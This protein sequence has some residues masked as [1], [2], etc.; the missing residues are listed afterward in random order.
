ML[1]SARKTQY[2]N[3]RKNSLT[4]SRPGSGPIIFRL[5]PARPDEDFFRWA[6]PGPLN[7]LVGPARPA[8]LRALIR[9][10][11]VYGPFA[12]P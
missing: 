5:G 2:K 8:G 7:F 11:P 6:R 3:D 1:F 4:S 12:H 9:P 10:G